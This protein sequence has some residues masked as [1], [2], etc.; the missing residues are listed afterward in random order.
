MSVSLETPRLRL[1]QWRPEDLD[2]FAA[3]M[4]EP[5][6]ARFLSHDQ[7]PMDRATAWWHMALL[8]GH[9]GMR[10]YGLF[11]VEE[12]ATGAWVGRVGPWQPEG[13][14]GFEIGWA[15]RRQFWGKGYATEAARAAGNWAFA[16]FGLTRIV[17]L[18]HDD[19]LA[20]RKVAARLGETAGEQVQHAGQPHTVWSASREAWRAAATR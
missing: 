19:N 9:W 12:K 11:V 13:W 10:G 20:S 1:R 7:Q 6:V 18:I 17:S 15:L 4:A 5:E 8:V 16:E 2:G 3:L 14:P